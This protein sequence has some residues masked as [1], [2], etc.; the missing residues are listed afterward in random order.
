[1]SDIRKTDSSEGP[2]ARINRYFSYLDT[3]E[4]DMTGFLSDR[5]SALE[6]QV[7]ELKAELALSARHPPGDNDRP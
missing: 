5:M 6:S 4:A 7:A 3:T 2:W 1:M